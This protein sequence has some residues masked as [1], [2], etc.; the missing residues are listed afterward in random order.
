MIG[1]AVLYFFIAKGLW[2]GE[3]WARITAIVLSCLGVL[4]A[5]IGLGGG[6]IGSNLVS[7]IINGAIGGYLWFSNEAKT[8]F[9]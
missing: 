7:L 8:A 5:I 1:F 2:N 9:A 4:F 6:N 3:S